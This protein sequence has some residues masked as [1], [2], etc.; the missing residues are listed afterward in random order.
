MTGVQTCALPISL[1]GSEPGPL[2]F[3][4]EGVD[5]G[6]LRGETVKAPRELARALSFRSRLASPVLESAP[7]VL[8]KSEWPWSSI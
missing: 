1:A 2:H 3:L 6:R 8:E 4:Q 7:K 5:T